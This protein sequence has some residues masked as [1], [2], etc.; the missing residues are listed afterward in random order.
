MSSPYAF[1]AAINPLSLG[2]VSIALLRELFKRDETPCVFTMMG[3]QPDLSAQVPDPAF[4][5]KLQACLLSAH[6]RYNRKAPCL[7]QWHIGGSLESLCERGNHLLTYME[8][9]QL[10]PSEVNTLRQQAKVYVT[11]RFTAQ[12]MSQYGI[13]AEYLPIGFDAHNH[14]VLAARPRVEGALSFLLPGK[15]EKRKGHMQVLRAW[16][17][18]YGNNPAYRLN[19]AL[20]NPFLPPERAN[21]MVTE[22]L[23]GKQYWNIVFHQWAPDNA[24]YNV[25]LQSSE[26]VIAMSGGEGRDLPCYH[27][28]AMGAWP[29]AMRAHAYLDY[30]NDSNAVLV[31]P[32]GK[33]PAADGVHFAQNGPF[34]SGNIFTF[35]DAE[36]IAACE[37]A[38]KRARAGINT[39]GLAL[40]Q[41]TYAEAVDI[42]LRDLKAAS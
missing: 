9:D 29:V 38:E 21:A 4:D 1:H 26:V 40:Q 20:H 14:K 34:N 19:C 39:A 25:T 37:E 12:V 3:S 7:K 17:K 5:Q 33:Q 18:R 27:A 13:T 36:F 23:E 11:S 31:S 22:A 42:L 28:T 24:T 8:L 6:Q 15:L 41:T 35:D 10:T 2:S 16:A 30:L 32:N